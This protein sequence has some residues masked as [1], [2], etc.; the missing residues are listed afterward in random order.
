M[1]KRKGSDFDATMKAAV[2]EKRESL[3]LIG[4][5]NAVGY[6]E[7]RDYNSPLR[8]ALS[9]SWQVHVAAKSGTR[10]TTIAHD[11]DSS[12]QQ[13]YS[14]SRKLT[15]H[16]SVQELKEL[17]KAMFSRIVFVL[18]TNDVPKKT[19]RSST[20]KKLGPSVT[21]VLRGVEK[22]LTPQTNARDIFVTAPFCFEPEHATQ[23][24]CDLLE[25]SCQ[26]VG[27]TYVKVVGGETLPGKF[28]DS[29]PSQALQ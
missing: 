29:Y 25:R 11:V 17:P 24:M 8:R 21:A 4:D 22:Y 7:T 15:A 28:L 18:G 9:S 10:W 23:D 12:L 13:F 16:G 6:C 5:S 27:V 19:A 1:G 26:E 3:L 2:G 14:A 20:W